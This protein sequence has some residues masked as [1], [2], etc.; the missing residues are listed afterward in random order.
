MTDTK[1]DTGPAK[2]RI[3]LPAIMGIALL[4]FV[5]LVAGTTWALQDR[6]IYGS[7]LP[8]IPAQA[9]WR[10]TTIPVVDGT[11]TAYQHPGKAGAKTLLFLHGG[12][13]GYAQA[14]L[15]TK[16]FVDAGMNVVILEYPGRGGNAGT[17]GIEAIQDAGR[18][19]MGWLKR[20]GVKADDIVIY[21]QGVGA[22]GA[23]AAAQLPHGRLL[24]VSGIVDVPAMVATRYPYVAR[25][26]IKDEGPAGSL[27]ALAKVKGKTTIVHS[28]EDQLSPFRNAEEMAR[29][30]KTQV[31][32]VPGGHPI[33]F[34]EG[35]QQALVGSVA[36]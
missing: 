1:A 25:W 36:R 35:L 33:A 6:L 12:G 30:T 28:P 3:S 14:M 19:A 11:I 7:P 5:A 21:G 20:N 17:M 13:Q 26:L 16:G 10:A 32:S 22:T 18:G 4:L 29:I 2:R 8:Q 15:A 27:E 31:I 34:N 24:I 23:I 9:G